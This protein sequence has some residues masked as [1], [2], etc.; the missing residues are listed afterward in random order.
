M[1]GSVSWSLFD[2]G[3]IQTPS[4]RAIVEA[5]YST[6]RR[7]IPVVYLLALMNVCGL[8]IATGGRLAPGFNIPTVLAACGLLRV[9]QWLPDRE[10]SHEQMLRRMQQTCLLGALIC[11]SVFLWCARILDTASHEQKMAVILFGGLTAIG[12]AYGLSALQTAARMP[13]IVLSLPLAALS[14]VSSDPQF[15]GAAI[16]L[17]VVSGLILRLLSVHDAHFT[18]LVR[19]RSSLEHQQQLAEHARQ[20]AIVAATTDF[21]TKLPNRRAFVAALEAE[22]ERHSGDGSF[23]VGIVDLDRFKAVN[24]T[25]GHAAGDKLLET[26]A[27]RLLQAAGKSALVARLGGDE[28]G[29]LFPNITCP[30]AAKETGARVLAEVNRPVTIHGRQLGVSACCGLGI[31]RRGQARTTSGVLSH[32]DLALYQAKEDG[33]GEVS[34]FEP[35]MEAPRRRRAQIEA[36]LRLPGVHESIHLVFQPIIDLRTGQVVANEALARW[37]D[38]ELGNVSPSEFVPL[39]EQLNVI[40]D[41]SCHLMAKAFAEAASWPDPVRLSFNLSAVQLCSTGSAEAILAGLERAGLS[42]K[43]LQV[44]VTETALLADF[45]RAR[46]SLAK[47]RTQGVTI[48]LDDFG[49]GYASIGYLREMSFDQIKLDGA[50]VTAAQDNSDGQR[51][52]A[53][54]I[55]LCDA[56]G[57]STVAEHVENEQQLKLLVELGCTA[58]QGFWLQAPMPAQALRDFCRAGSL[59]FETRG[60]AQ[61]ARRAAHG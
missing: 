14:F 20:E 9:L 37:R 50:L 34:V 57:V 19:S 58:G 5:R 8:Q 33:C 60:A 41:I 44:E 53:A 47:L 23:A 25:F 29:L 26:V 3:E 51:L 35:Q 43:R 39:A 48:V 21:L 31:S 42:T 30:S 36:A 46:E 52:L 54:V 49:A 27:T 4:G 11:L 10:V 17:A 55:G 38:E 1:P 6:L 56:L 28:F 61:A 32:A 15:I 24:D 22:I 45:G 2:V 59:V 13:L 7:Q 16:S 40:G 12:I 18:D